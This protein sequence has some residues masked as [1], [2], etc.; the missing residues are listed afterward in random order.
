MASAGENIAKALE[1]KSDFT[2]YLGQDRDA[3]EIK[4]SDDF[5][6][7]IGYGAVGKVVCDLLDR[8]LIKY[9]GIE[10]DPNKAIQA[11]N[12]GLPVFYGDIGRQEVAEAFNVGKA[13]AVV[14]C[15]S[16]RD[17]AN[18][19]VIALR[20][21]YPNV[22]IFSRAKNKDHAYRLQSTL[23]VAAMVP[24][25]PEDNL[26]LTLP[27]GGAV[28]K[29]LGGTPEEVNAILESKRKEVMSGISLVE[30][31]ED[32]ALVQLGIDP[33]ER[34]K[35]KENKTKSAEE[36]HGDASPSTATAPK[37]AAANR[38]E[39]TKEKSP[40]VAE[41]IG[42]VF[43]EAEEDFDPETN[44]SSIDESSTINIELDIPGKN[45]IGL[46]IDAV[47]PSED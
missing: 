41:V 2:H 16:D 14:V 11:R 40:F 10:I 5:A 39:E 46:E 20:R 37:S 13:K 8:K 45:I 24:I 25:L 33:K 22:K 27:F 42:D 38:I 31:E 47:I 32:M 9:V 17:Q 26:L 28:L 35:E 19:A 6:V 36:D 21:W 43:P 3:N 7:V 44:E 12:S 4:E 1:E 18:R 15:I 34:T 29:A 30:T 23:N